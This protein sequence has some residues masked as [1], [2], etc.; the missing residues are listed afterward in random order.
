MKLL[1]LKCLLV[2]AILHN[3]FVL[4]TSGCSCAALPSLQCSRVAADLESSTSSTATPTAR[5]ANRA[6]AAGWER[7]LKAYCNQ[8]DRGQPTNSAFLHRFW[9]TPLWPMSPPAVGE[10]GV[11]GTAGN[12]WWRRRDP[13]VPAASKG[14]GREGAPRYWLCPT[15]HCGRNRGR[16]GASQTCGRCRFGDGGSA[17]GR[18]RSQLCKL[19]QRQPWL[20]SSRCFQQ[21][22]GYIVTFHV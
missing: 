9:R 19:K 11:K 5:Q 13:V 3:P 1:S 16:G 4:G 7:L 10:L 2:R 22:F 12:T 15:P 17:S 14:R 20:P 21:R 18:D 6:R 8:P